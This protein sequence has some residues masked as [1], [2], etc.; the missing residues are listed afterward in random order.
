MVNVFRGSYFEAMNI[1]NVLEN[2]DIEVFTINEYM[3]GIEPW[4]VTSGGFNP[5]LL[6]V[7]EDDFKKA[8]KL[9]Q[10]YLNGNLNL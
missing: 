3:S 9:V 10:D 6:K 5:V 2:I 7:N 8:D 1:R 4:I